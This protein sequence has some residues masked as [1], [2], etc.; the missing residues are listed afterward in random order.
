VTRGY[1]PD[2]DFDLARGERQEL[3]VEGILSRIRNGAEVEVK[4]DFYLN[5]DLFME[6]SDRRAGRDHYRDTGFRTSRSGLYVL[7]KPGLNVLHIYQTGDLRRLEAAALLGPLL[8]GGMRGDCPTRGY[9]RTASQIDAA[10][11]KLA[12][13]TDPLFDQDAS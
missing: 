9:R 1:Q 11:A 12:R 7:N 2:W 10:L 5:A 6:V 8:D 3:L 13:G 4:S